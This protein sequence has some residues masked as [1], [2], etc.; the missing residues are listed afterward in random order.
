MTGPHDC[1]FPTDEEWARIAA[2]RRW[3]R[4]E[5][6]VVRAIVTG[7]RRADAATALGMSLST[8]QTH[9]R[10]ALWKCRCTD[11]V[12]LIWLVTDARDRLRRYRAS[13]VASS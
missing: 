10:R 11:V 7:S 2:D 9:L 5:A 3:S 13:P 4:R 1:A 12:A 6:Q 8:L